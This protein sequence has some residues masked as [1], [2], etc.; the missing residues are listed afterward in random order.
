MADGSA[1]LIV[2]SGTWHQVHWYRSTVVQRVHSTR[3]GITDAYHCMVDAG[4][5]DEQESIMS[6]VV[7]AL[8]N[9]AVT[10]GQHDC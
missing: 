6:V 10:Q 1:W 5:L 7:K 8:H 3:R 4:F 2:L 9:G